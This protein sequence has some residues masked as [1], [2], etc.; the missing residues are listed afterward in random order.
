PKRSHSIAMKIILGV[1]VL[2]FA[3]V[4]IFNVIK[5]KMIEKFIAGAGGKNLS[6]NCNDY[7][8]S[9]MDTRD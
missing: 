1:I 9:A 5:G 6:R 4:I 3:G 7:S 8:A 2:L